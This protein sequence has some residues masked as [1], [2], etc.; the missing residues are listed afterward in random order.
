MEKKYGIIK[1]FVLI[2]LTILVVFSY[3][4]K[5]QAISGTFL[6]NLSNFTGTIPYSWPRVRVDKENHEVYVLYQNLIRVFNESGMEIYSFGEQLDVGS[7]VDMEIDKEGDIILL[8]YKWSEFRKKN[9]FQI[10]RCNYRG[11]PVSKIEIKNIH[12]KFSE[13]L[14]NRMVYKSGELYL[15]SLSSMMVAIVDE[16]GNFK[17]GFDILPMLELEEKEKADAMMD[18]FWVDQEGNILFSVP[19][20]FRVYKLYSDGKIEYFGRP[21]SS[22]GRFNIVAGIV[23]DRRGNILAVDKLKCSIMVFDKNFKFITQFSSRG[24]K[25]GYLISP[26]DITID[27]KDRIYVTQ[28]AKRGVSVFKLTYN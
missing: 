2:F 8:S 7:I 6:Y 13:F 11:E 28:G 3:P 9:N 1:F 26:D 15:A 25:P 18:G 14:P 12:P 24:Y 21:G 27:G 16:N 5:L 20:L 19:P 4:L 17:K 22:P 23:T 10:T